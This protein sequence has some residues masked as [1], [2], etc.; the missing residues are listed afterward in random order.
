MRL[1]V[2]VIHDEPSLRELLGEMLEAW[3]THQVTVAR[4]GFDIRLPSVWHQWLANCDLFVVGLERRY[5]LGLRAEGVKVAE[6]LFRAGK[7][8]LVVGSEYSANQIS[9]RYYWDMGS[10][11]SFLET[12]AECL[13]APPPTTDELAALVQYFKPRLAIPTGHARIAEIH[14]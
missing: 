9:L 4:S 3:T 12:I 11:R 8:V 13:E 14:S 5:E 6:T 1:S 2:V 10:K 7:R